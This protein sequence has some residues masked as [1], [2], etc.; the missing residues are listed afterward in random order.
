MQSSIGNAVKEINKIIEKL[1]EFIANYGTSDDR[2]RSLD[3]HWIRVIDEEATEEKNVQGSLILN[4]SRAALDLQY[5]TWSSICSCGQPNC[6]EEFMPDKNPVSF[7]YASIIDQ[8]NVLENQRL[9]FTVFTAWLKAIERERQNW[10]GVM[11]SER[12]GGLRISM[13]RQGDYDDELDY[14]R[15]IIDFLEVITKVSMI[16][17][18][19]QNALKD[20]KALQKRIERMRTP[21]RSTGLANKIASMKNEKYDTELIENQIQELQTKVGNGITVRTWGWEVEAPAPGDDVV[22]PAGV[23]RG[24]DGSVE[25]WEH[26]DSSDCEC[27]CSDCTY[28]DCTCEN[29][30]NYND[31][32]GHCGGDYCMSGSEGA[33]FRTTGGVQRMQHPGLKNLLNQIGDTEKNPTA[34]THIHVYA[35]DLNAEQ[36]GVVLGG[37]AITQKVWDVIAGRDVNTDSRCQTYANIIPADYVAYTIRNKVLKHVGKFNAVNTQHINT[38]RGTLEFRQMN[39]NFD[40]NRITLMAWMAR[41]L[42]ESAK[43]GAKVHEFFNIKDIDGMVKL[44]E[45]YS[46]TLENEW[47]SQALDNPVGSRYNQSRNRIATYD[48]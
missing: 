17:L 30:E 45:K 10:Q 13:N 34:G 6:D 14:A 39:C 7:E 18:D 40:Y 44:Y 15:Q 22:T 1:K 38:E 24:Y 42:V 20:Y 9:Q 4:N 29:C 48:E 25:S 28:H 27:D 31:D 35:K 36:V 26:R 21:D 12:N 8:I 41:G 5:V 11:C 23:D 19:V 46:Y 33:E 3:S 2:F 16:N 47:G 32:P 37:Y 43:R